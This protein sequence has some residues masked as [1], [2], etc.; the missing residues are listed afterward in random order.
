MYSAAYVKPS[1]T[2]DTLDGTAEALS[3]LGSASELDPGTPRLAEP[4]AGVPLLES[5]STTRTSEVSNQA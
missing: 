1:S 3:G 2:L 4:Q 5:L